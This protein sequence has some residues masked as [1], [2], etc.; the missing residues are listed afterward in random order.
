MF[1]PDTTVEFCHQA[2]K[3]IAQNFTRPDLTV[4]E[5]SQAVSVDP[6]RLRAGFVEM[7]GM[8]PKEYTIHLRI[9]KSKK[10][11]VNSDSSIA[12][13]AERLGFSNS[14]YFSRFFCERTGFYPTE[15]RNKFK[16]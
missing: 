2:E 6:A 7:C 5:V 13:V 8:T 15:Y 1:V 16:F 14:S 9:V 12:R 3:Y 4:S 10:L 11:L